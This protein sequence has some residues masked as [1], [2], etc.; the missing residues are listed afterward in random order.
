MSLRLKNYE[1][2]DKKDFKINLSARSYL[3]IESNQIQSVI[4]SVQPED[5]NKIAIDT[6]SNFNPLSSYDDYKNKNNSYQH[7][8]FGQQRFSPNAGTPV[9]AIF[10][11]MPSIPNPRPPQSYMYNALM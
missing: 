1:N 2:V 4:K 9:N 6:K 7:Q 10:N 8:N 3:S 11:S 5:K